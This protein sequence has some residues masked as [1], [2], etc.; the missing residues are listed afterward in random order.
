MKL[1]FS[2]TV[3]SFY[4]LISSGALAQTFVDVTVPAG[5]NLNPALGHVVVWIDHNQ[6][7]WLD[8][9][10]STDQESFFYENNGDGTFTDITSQ[11]GLS[12]LDTESLAVADYNCDG[13]PDLL[14]TSNNQSIPAKVYKNNVGNGFTEAFIAEDGAYRAIWLDYNYDGHLDMFCNTGYFPLLFLN[15]GNG[16][17][18]NVADDMGFN[19]NSGSTSAVSDYNNDGLLDIYCT[20][21]SGTNRL[22]KN[23][24]GENFIDVTFEAQVSDFRDGVA[25]CWGDYN[26][27]GWMDLYIANIGSNR[28]ILFRNEGNGTFDDVTIAAG[29]G[30]AGDARTCSWLDVNNDGLL[31]LFTTNHINPNKLYLNNG[32]ETFS[33][34]ASDLSIDSP[35]DGFGLS[36]GD[37]DR[38]GDL[39]VLIA[40]HFGPLNL[41]RNDMVIVDHY[42]D[43]LLLGNYDNKTGI[44]ARITVFFEGESS[45]RE[46]NGGTGARSQD[47]TELHFG[48]GSTQ[49]VDS[50]LI[51]WPSGMK[52]KLFDIAANQLITIEQEGNVPPSYFHLLEPNPDSIVAGQ[53]VSFIW[54]SS[55]DPDSGNQ[56]EY[57]VHLHTPQRD[58]VIG[59]L[60]DTTIIIDMKAWMESD[61]TYW[62]VKASDGFDY[63]NSWEVWLLNYSYYVNIREQD[64]NK[65]KRFC[66]IRITPQPVREIMFVNLVTKQSGRYEFSIYNIS[67]GI[68]HI[69][70]FE[71]KSGE[72]QLMFDVSSLPKGIYF[73][74][75][76]S[77]TELQT[78]KI[79]IN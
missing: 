28:N 64:I 41:L 55:I 63:R 23:L 13:Y 70:H 46:V 22:Y 34:V 5:I 1:T 33:D 75:I 71:L 57:F 26:D 25:Q 11:S 9:F 76:S 42:L 68:C 67:G 10:G 32:N 58:T 74:S 37:Y 45:I 35:I 27:D 43:V 47:A 38:D 3:V 77:G 21:N 59:P 8:F 2:A 44:G 52:Q 36:W 30:D 54:R 61:S 14:I 17:F 62:F 20:T 12:S 18:T 69:Q 48:L 31:D 79:V 72:N 50:I 53:Q 19:Q 6:D 49:M 56:I 73:L 39:D 16:N 4:L 24:A 66:E 7:G 29:V 51:L 15:D 78:T 40:G 60:S 65:F